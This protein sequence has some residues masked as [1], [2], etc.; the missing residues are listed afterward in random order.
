MNKSRTVQNIVMLPVVAATLA[1]TWNV[2]SR[3]QVRTIEECTPGCTPPDDPFFYLTPEDIAVAVAIM[4][5][6][7]SVL[8]L[9]KHPEY[10]KKNRLGKLFENS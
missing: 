9:R 6:V 1:Y 10:I 2:V 8:Y 7:V 5:L 3:K 4:A